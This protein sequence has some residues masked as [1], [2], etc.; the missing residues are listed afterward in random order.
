MLKKTMALFFVTVFL[1]MAIPAA[2]VFA[3]GEHNLSATENFEDGLL[4]ATYFTNDFSGAEVRD[5]IGRDGGKALF[6]SG[7]GG[8]RT[9]NTTVTTDDQP[10]LSFDF[11]V[12]KMPTDFSADSNGDILQ[13]AHHDNSYTI[14]VRK[15][16]D[17]KI[18]LVHRTDPTNCKVEIQKDKWYRI[19]EAT[20]QASTHLFNY[21]LD[22]NGEKLFRQRKWNA[23]NNDEN[24]F[25]YLIA[26]TLGGSSD[27]EF[28][29]DNITYSVKN[30][31]T[32][33][34]ALVYSSIANN[35]TGVSIVTRSMQVRFDSPFVCA[36]NVWPASLA[37]VTITPAGG[38][39]V[40][41][42]AAPAI[43]WFSSMDY[44]VSWPMDLQPSTTYTLDFSGCQNTSG[45]AA[46]G[47][48]TFTT[49][50]AS[51][52]ESVLYDGFEDTSLH[53]NTGHTY[54]G[55]TAPFY[56]NWN[57]FYSDGAVTV[58][59]AYSGNYALKVSQINSSGEKYKARLLAR[60]NYA[61][62][63]TVVLTYRIKI[64]NAAVKYDEATKLY[65]EGNAIDFGLLSDATYAV[66]QS[67]S[68]A[69]IALDQ[70]NGQHYIGA[71]L[72]GAFSSEDTAGR[73]GYYYTED[74]WYNVIRTIGSGKQSFALID[75]ES[76][77]KLFESS[78]E[79][80]PNSNIIVIV[81]IPDGRNNND[82][83][84]NNTGASVT[85][86]DVS[87]WSLDANAEAHKL[88]VTLP[89]KTEYD[90][91]NEKI[92]LT[93]N[94][95]VMPDRH[96]VE[97]Y[98]G[99][100][101]VTSTNQ[102]FKV[103]YKDF[104]KVELD[105][106]GLDYA[107]DYTIDL[108]GIKSVAGIAMKD[109]TNT[110]YHFNTKEDSNHAV[111]VIGDVAATGFAN[112]AISSGATLSF[113]INNNTAEQNV[114]SRLIA[115]V[116]KTGGE[117]LGVES[118]SKEITDDTA[119]LTFVNNYSDVCKIKLFALDNFVNLKP[120]GEIKEI[121]GGKTELL[122]IGNSLSED[123]AAY[124]HDMAEASGV[125]LNQ[126]VMLVGGADISHHAANLRAD[127]AD[128][129]YE[130][131]GGDKRDKYYN[132]VNGQVHAQPWKKLTQA[133]K[134]KKYDIITLQGFY[135]DGESY[136]EKS[137]QDLSYLV[138]EIKKLHPNAKIMLY[139]I[140]PDYKGSYI[141]GMVPADIF[142]CIISP[143]TREWA[144]RLGVEVIPSGAAFVLAEEKYGDEFNHQYPDSASNTDPGV[145][146][147]AEELLAGSK[148]LYRDINHASYYGR[149]LTDAVIFESVTGAR[150]SDTYTVPAPDGVT[151]HAG[152][153]AKLR[154]VAHKAVLEAK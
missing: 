32:Y 82:Y 2:G 102:T 144:D 16:D 95:P 17:N 121:W 46:T 35:A 81:D 139:E 48:V 6:V 40:S 75:P 24:A 67:S 65:T 90:K 124:L 73:K 74:K 154:E 42:T 4:D 38:T 31:A 135:Y 19:G 134:A 109:R 119:A 5:G 33:G 122:M 54:G 99:D 3:A 126:T 56:S 20:D 150:P 8:I 47:A 152:N 78:K 114:S 36:N 25:N 104:N 151:D 92:L 71:H 88:A 50:V 61:A 130:P 44:T 15:D 84:T 143:V 128:P 66:S 127:L 41:C 116:Y 149:Y 69:W 137:F 93:F 22:E 53:D 105:L 117:L 60:N 147:P 146:T 98:Y 79:K 111:S 113:R 96:E 12:T 37:G 148:G 138:T 29:I 34:P 11:K 13:L 77:E 131:E 64:K 112:G 10:A 125:S 27:M 30:K 91:N 83:S 14:S 45:A 110:L 18:Y 72:P 28:V 86:D 55:T 100:E 21:V 63:K 129:D 89:T 103:S 59:D 97:V 87:M 39:P 9:K 108:N 118:V 49:G 68:V 51:L 145:Q 140:W 23:T 94:Q 43:D 1:V 57:T 70:H 132:Y 136:S 120:L 76:G 123:S 85:V 58:T 62:D 153:L 101:C 7:T 133:L 106:T 80:D 141:P 115:A 26:G 107:S 142:N 52:E